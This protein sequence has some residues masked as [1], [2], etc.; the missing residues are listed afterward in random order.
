MIAIVH[1]SETK[2]QLNLLISICY[3]ESWGLIVAFSFVQ[4]SNWSIRNSLSVGFGPRDKIAELFLQARL[5]RG[6]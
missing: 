5:R 2:R 4:Q 6:C 3:V 1:G